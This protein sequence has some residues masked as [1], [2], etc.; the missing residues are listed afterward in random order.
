MVD[1][2]DPPSGDV[3]QVLWT[4]AIQMH[5]TANYQ[6]PQHTIA[7]LRQLCKIMCK[8]DK[9]VSGGWF[10]LSLNVFRTTELSGGGCEKVYHV[11]QNREG[12]EL[13]E[14]GRAD[15]LDQLRRPRA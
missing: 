10:G 2:F 3:F 1:E 7:T 14:V 12:R 9:Y 13:P 6:R 4:A 8:E 15:V 11:I 5:V